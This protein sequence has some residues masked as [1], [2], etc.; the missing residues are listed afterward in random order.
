MFVLFWRSDENNST[1]VFL[2]LNFIIMHY[3][4]AY[5]KVMSNIQGNN[6]HMSA[7]LKCFNHSSCAHTLIQKYLALKVPNGNRTLKL[8][9]F[10]QEALASRLM[11]IL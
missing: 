9:L 4:Y 7:F 6:T 3:V 11:L 5:L 2:S 1:N 10:S 8:D